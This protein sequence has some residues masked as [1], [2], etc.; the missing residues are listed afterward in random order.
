MSN[1]A[2]IPARGGSKRISRK[3]VRDFFGLPIISFSIKSAI[4]SNLFDEVMVSTDDEEIAEVAISNGAK[5]PFFRSDVNSNDFATTFD[6]VNEVIVQYETAQIFFN[7]LCVI[8]P[9]APFVNADKLIRAYELLNSQDFDTV[10]PVV[11]YGNPIQR[12]LKFNG[13]RIEMF[14]PEFK[15]MRSQDM[16]PAFY[17]AGQF[18]WGKVDKV[19]RNKS[20]YSTNSGSLILSEFEAHDI[21]SEQDWLIAEMK[22]KLK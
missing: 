3:N 2:L 7:K 12:A 20:L 4:E 13:D 10:F 11:Q 17:D 9:C 19:M 18:Y 15:N 22:Y 14:N 16:E 21:D 8:Y 5:V 6:V 1:L